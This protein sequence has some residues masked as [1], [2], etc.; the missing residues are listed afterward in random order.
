MNNAFSALGHTAKDNKDNDSADTVSMQ[1]AT[2]TL[3]SQLTANTVA[4]TS[5]RQDQLYQ[6]LA[7]QQI[8][9][10]T[11][12]HQILDQ[13][14]ALSFNASNMGQEQAC[15]DGGGRGHTP[16]A[17]IHPS[18]PVQGTVP[19]Y[20]LGFGGRGRVCGRRCGYNAGCILPLFVGRVTFPPGGG[21]TAGNVFA[22][23][24][25]GGQGF[26]ILGHGGQQQA[27]APPYF[28]VMKQFANWN[29]C[30]S[31]GF[32]ISERAHEHVVPSPPLQGGRQCVLHASKRASVH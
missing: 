3:H 31:C 24:S 11:N 6:H 12:Q 32:D 26:F 29:A 17:Y 22:P 7:Q 16:P 30:Y 21:F 27:P 9:L 19:A 20:T 5:Q 18:I 13:L 14:A 10:H 1:V 8:L 28:N 4:N 15:H 2:L 23:P 25:A